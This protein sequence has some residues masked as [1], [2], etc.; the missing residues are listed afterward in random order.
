M[1]ENAWR[2]RGSRAGSGKPRRA[3]NRVRSPVPG[4][5]L[6]VLRK[7][8]LVVVL[9]DNAARKERASRVPSSRLIRRHAEEGCWEP[10]RPKQVVG[11]TGKPELNTLS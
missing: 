3:L 6:A 2:W 1:A 4:R 8:T 9:R 5:H 10:H 7:K 11:Q